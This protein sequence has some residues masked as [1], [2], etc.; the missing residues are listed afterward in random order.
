MGALAALAAVIVFGLAGVALGYHLMGPEARVV[1]WHKFGIGVLA[2]S[3][4]GAF[5]AFVIG[6]SVAARTAG[7]TRAEPAMLHG[8]I[9][10]LVVVPILVFLA[11][12]GGSNYI[13]GWYGG[14]A[15]TPSWAVASA[16]AR[17]PRWSRRTP[18]RRPGRRVKR[19]PKWPAT[20][21]WVPI[22]ALLLRLVG[23][24][25]GG[26]MASGEPMTFGH[27]TRPYQG[28]ARV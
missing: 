23:A 2:C 14:L 9:A 25:I 10:W 4:I 20:P 7:L 28:K 16:P 24:V 5:A 21:P 27:Y 15:G 13:G 22:T 1:D 26:W 17:R 18:R 19:P 3:V 8:A 12:L 11:A 6:G